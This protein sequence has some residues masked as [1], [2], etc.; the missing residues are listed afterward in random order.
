MILRLYS[1]TFVYWTWSLGYKPF[2]RIGSDT[3]LTVSPGGIAFFTCSPE[4]IAQVGRRHREFLKPTGLY[5]IVDAYVDD[6]L[7]YPASEVTSIIMVF[8]FHV[9]DAEVILDLD[10]TSLVQMAQHG[11]VSENP[12]LLPS[13]KATTP[14]FGPSQYFKRGACSDSGKYSRRCPLEVY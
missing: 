2:E 12:S 4:I 9:Y 7:F 1:F 6:L 11:V 3:I 14:S 13:P 10:Q 5:K 8:G